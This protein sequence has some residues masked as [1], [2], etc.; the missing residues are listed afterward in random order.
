MEKPTAEEVDRGDRVV[1]H[2]CVV[3]KL[4]RAVTL[5][6][7]CPFSCARGSETVKNL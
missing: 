4:T 5:Y 6:S 7:V 1:E 3:V 2:R